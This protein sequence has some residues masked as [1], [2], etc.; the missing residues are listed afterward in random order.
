MN[1]IYQTH[2]KNY[3]MNTYARYPITLLKGDGAY[4]WDANGKKYLDFL[5]GIGCTSLGHANPI[6]EQA[7]FEQVKKIVHTS[8]LYYSPP[9]IDLA[10]YLVDH[11]GL[12]KIFFCNSGTEANEAA[13]KL[14]RKYQWRKGKKNKNIILSATNSFHGRTLGSL[15]ATAKPILQEGFGPMPSAFKYQSWNDTKLFCDAIDENVAAVILEPI[16]GEGGI[17]IAPPDFLNA[18]RSACDAADA[19]LIFDE[20]QCGLGRTGNLFAY[21]TMNVIPDII[22][23]AKGIANGLP[24]GVVCAKNHIADA[25]K[26][27]DHGTTF[28][29]NPVSCAAALANLTTLLNQDYLHKIK[30]LSLYLMHRLEKLKRQCPTQIKTIRGIGLMIGIEL[31]IPPTA[32]LTHCQNSGLLINVT[33]ENVL[34]MLPPYV[35]TEEDIDFA[36]DVIEKS[37]KIASY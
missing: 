21:Q 19:L 3:L 27:K 25:F 35:I 33:A 31:T 7:I 34:R 23:L 18:V 12:D 24:L 37:L 14:A 28:G 36:I 32:V 13:I 29:G 4:V 2:S 26:P 15:A 16:Q 17:Q 6:I 30:K 9:S 5:S 8:N 11:G 22:T 10:K 1:D 20:V